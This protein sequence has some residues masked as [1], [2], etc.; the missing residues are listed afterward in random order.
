MLLLASTAASPMMVS[1]TRL[2]VSPFGAEACV[3]TALLVSTSD[4]N[5]C[6]PFTVS[7]QLLTRIDWP[8]YMVSPT[9]RLVLL[10]KMTAP[11]GDARINGK[12]VINQR[13]ARHAA[14]AMA[15]R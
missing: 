3:S 10:V 2:F 14:P 6:G 9:P 4:A 15:I 11:A 7:V 8:S 1:S 13:M 12:A 5:V